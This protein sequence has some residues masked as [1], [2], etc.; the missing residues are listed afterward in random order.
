MGGDRAE[1]RGRGF[2]VEARRA[3]V[4]L[5]GNSRGRALVRRRGGRPSPG[6]R[7]CRPRLGCPCG[8]SRAESSPRSPPRASPARARYSSLRAGKRPP[9]SL[10]SRSASCRSSGSATTSWRRSACGRSATWQPC[11]V[12]PSPSAWDGGPA[13]VAAGARRGQRARPGHAGPRPRSRRCWSFP[14]R[15]TTSS[16]CGGRCRRSSSGRSA[17]RSGGTWS[18]QGGAPAGARRRRLVAAHAHSS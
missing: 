10:R 1:A 9:S 13:G 8:R 2:A 7:R 16:R 14:S 5:R 18:P 4:S 11:R 3:G 6:A 12:G 17:V 15:W